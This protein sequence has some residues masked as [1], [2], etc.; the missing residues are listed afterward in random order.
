[1]KPAAPV[2][3][4]HIVTRLGDDGPS[5]GVLWLCKYMDRTRYRL[6]V[7]SMDT[8]S[9]DAVAEL[10]ELGLQA[11]G[12]GAESFFDMRSVVKI[13]KLIGSHRPSIVHTHCLR[14]D[15]YGRWA[16]RLCRV[17]VVC[18]TVRNE[19]DLCFRAE[20]PAWLVPVL[21]AINRLSARTADLH[22]PVS[23]GVKSFVVDRLK[24]PP[25]KVTYVPNGVDLSRFRAAQGST[26]TVRERLNLPRNSIVIGTVAAL[27]PQK[28]LDHLLEAARLVRSRR[29]DAIFVVFGA[30][31]LESS[32]RR[33]IREAEMDAGFILGGQ[34]AHI[35]T[36]LPGLDIFVLPSLWE[37]MPR[38][39]LE[40]M[41]AGRACVATDIGGSRELIENGRC[42][43]IVPSGR[44]DELALAIEALVASLEL[45]GR[46][47]SAASERVKQHFSAEHVAGLYADIYDKLLSVKRSTSAANERTRLRPAR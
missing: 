25:E 34:Q 8:P 2:E 9:R 12:L 14:P 31:P 6:T 39:L 27:K 30:G 26:D 47:G 19:D 16:A 28:G 7:A 32:L 11:V 18:S 23:L 42:G 33:K 46:L 40:A 29:P 35:E 45:R 4:L 38:A 5:R 24:V 43:L 3:V 22:L 13:Q 21:N 17:P 15:W 1:M 41:A 10:E 36:L 37:G 44:A 20:A